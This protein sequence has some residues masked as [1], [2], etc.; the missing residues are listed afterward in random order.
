MYPTFRPDAALAVR[1]PEAFS[2]WVARLENASGIEILSFSH[3]LDAL[4]QR[5]DH[6]HSVGSRLSDHGLTRCFAMP[7]TDTQAGMIFSRARDGKPA[8]PSEEEQFA[9]YLMLFFGRLD[10]EKN[11]T[12]QLHLGALRNVNTRATQALGPNTGY[13]NI[14]DWPQAEALSKYLDL[15]EQENALP[16]NDHLQQQPHRQFRFLNRDR[17]L[18]GRKNSR[19]NSIRQRLVV[20]RSK[21]GNRVAAQRAFEQRPLRSIRRH[22][23]RLAL[24]YVIPAP[25]IFS[26]RALQFARE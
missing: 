23:H 18:S 7:C 22:A 4:K 11:W 24:V 21:R 14:G 15:L 2:S 12:K 16:E 17:Q 1:Q 25:R 6:F 8:T 5:H 26:P 13:D 3:F 10:A 9:S 20:P 19:Q